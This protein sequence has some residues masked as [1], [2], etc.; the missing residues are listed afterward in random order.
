MTT[1]LDN[2]TTITLLVI[3][4]VLN[5]RRAMRNADSVYRRVWITTMAVCAYEA[6][7]QALYLMGAGL[8]MVVYGVGTA[9]MSG[10]LVLNVIV[11]RGDTHD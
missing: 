11:G 10:V 2:I 3:A 1:P 4:I 9:L 7:A 6:M 8:P 5:G